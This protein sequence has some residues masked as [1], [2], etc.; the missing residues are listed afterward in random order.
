M[1]AFLKIDTCKDC[2]RAIPWE[3]SPVI[4]FG[5]KALAGT[6]IWHSQLIDGQC[7]ACV[8][9][10]E[11]QRKKEQ[12]DLAIRRDLVHLLG[13]EKP[14][15]EFTFERYRVTPENQLAYHRCKNF[16]PANEN[17]YL[18]GACGVGK[19]HLAYAIARTCFE[20]TLSTTILQ[21]YQLSRKVRMKEPDQEQS[22]INEL[23]CTEILLL[24][25]L[26]AG[27]DTAFSRQ[28]L[29]EILDRRDFNDRDGLLVTSKYSLDDLAAKLA[30]D[31]I[32]SRLGGMCQVIEVNGID[33][34]QSKVQVK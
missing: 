27:P 32:P 18:W 5:T 23:A 15:R 25:D 16:N 4:L 14:Y 30:D 19:T 8:T 21:A 22:A 10:H 29:Q 12:R 17:L 34:R 7:P 13:G 28:I 24:D 3:W 6:G 31:S 9:A 1:T 20:E 2:H 11:A 33:R 26:G